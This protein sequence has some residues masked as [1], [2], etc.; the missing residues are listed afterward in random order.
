MTLSGS[1][2]SGRQWGA[3]ILVWGGALGM[4]LADNLLTL[5]FGWMMCDAGILIASLQAK[6]PLT[7]IV[8]RIVVNLAGGMALLG[9]AIAL[10]GQEA[11]GL[12]HT[13][14][15][16]PFRWLV[17]FL[18][19]GAVRAGMY[20]FHRSTYPSTRS[21]LQPFA[22]ARVSVVL[23]GTYL[24]LR[25]L[26]AFQIQAAWWPFIVAAGGFIALI[27]GLLAWSTRGSQ[28][29]LARIVEFELGVM[30]LNLGLNTHTTRLMAALELFNAV[31]GVAVLGTTIGAATQSGRI[32]RIWNQVL[33]FAALASILGLPP[34][35]GFVARWGLYRHA[36]ETA[37]LSVVLPV[38]VA[39]GLLV[40]PLLNVLRS[41]E[42]VQSPIRGWQLAGTLL[43]GGVLI[44]VSVQPLFLSFIL[45]PLVRVSPYPVMRSLI[46]GV[47]SGLGM[48]IVLLLLIPVLLGYSLDQVYASLGKSRAMEAISR[49]L[50]LGWLYEVLISAA[51][52]AAIALGIIL[53]F[54]QA[55]STVEWAILAVLILL[56]ILLR[57]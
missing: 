32:K 10:R 5:F 13:I 8:N 55:S 48:R 51:V 45:D 18:I 54:L 42:A 47:D 40:A 57:W 35:V 29:L 9:G 3:A 37:S 22:L 31:L 15:A 14:S 24:W 39:G 49:F 44:V 25:G 20:P 34:T 7:G 12:A 30:L 21:F 19:A 56:L 52:R 17:W 46:R 27:S 4:V 2:I 11:T 43:V 53:A 33:T 41:N 6:E 36:W 23:A 16:L 28:Q 26:P 1:S 38:A 50:D